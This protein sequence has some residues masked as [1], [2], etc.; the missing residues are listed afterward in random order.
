MSSPSKYL[1]HKVVSVLMQTERTP[2]DCN[3]LVNY[4]CNL[5]DLT[6]YLK[7]VPRETLMAMADVVKAEHFAPGTT[8]FNKGDYSDRFYLIVRGDIEIFN[9]N[10]KGKITFSLHLGNGRR[11]GEQGVMTSQPRSLSAVVTESTVM[12]VVTRTQ[13]KKYLLAGFLT[14]LEVQ[15]VY[16]ERFLP[17]IEHYSPQQRIMIAYCLKTET[18]RRGQVILPKGV[19][20]ANFYIV[21][22]GEAEILADLPTGPKRILKLAAGSLF[23][24]EG[25]FLKE[26]T[27][28]AVVCASERI[29]LF[30]MRKFDAKKVLPKDIQAS[31][32]QHYEAKVQNRK[33]LA[34]SKVRS[35]STILQ[36]K[37]SVQSP[38]RSFVWATPMARKKLESMQISRT[39]STTNLPIK[40]NSF[41][42]R[43]S[44]LMRISDDTIGSTRHARMRTRYQ[45]S[46]STPRLTSPKVAEGLPLLCLPKASSRSIFQP[47]A[48]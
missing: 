18:C 27:K 6:K 34:D 2:E 47:I 1:L 3:L 25:V 20:A 5:P 36:V 12:L 37:Q 40:D 4:L 15:L 30:F 46:T 43:K 7:A 23:G 29:H 10:R 41:Q 38:K 13:F 14:E 33:S 48:R 39:N 8:L 24:E 35:E 31:I 11:L 42:R 26:R 22:D 19:M 17:A 44:A 28:Y 9:T 21:I 16:I 32:C 45:L